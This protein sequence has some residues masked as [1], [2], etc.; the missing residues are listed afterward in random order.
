MYELKKSTLL[1]F[2]I[3]ETIKINQTEERGCED[4]SKKLTQN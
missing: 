3:V 2:K 4:R 1:N